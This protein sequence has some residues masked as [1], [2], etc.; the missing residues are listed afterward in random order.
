MRSV[1]F[2]IWL[3][4]ALACGFLD[5][6][7]G[8]NHGEN[9]TFNCNSLGGTC[10]C[11]M[12]AASGQCG[13]ATAHFSNAVCDGGTDDHV[14]M[15]DWLT[16][17]N[18]FYPGVSPALYVPPVCKLHLDPN[19]ASCSFQA[20]VLAGEVG[21]PNNSITWAYGATTDC[22]WI[23]GFAYPN[24]TVSGVPQQALINTVTAGSSTV[25]VNDGNIGTFSIG[26]SIAVTGLVTIDNQSGNPSHQ[27]FEYKKITNIVGNVITLDSPLA[28]SYESTWPSLGLGD[29]FH[30]ALGG[31][32]L[33][34]LLDATWDV[35]GTIYGIS[36]TYS[37]QVN[38]VGR[39]ISAIDVT[40]PTP[41]GYAPTSSKNVYISGGSTPTIEVDKNIEVFS[42]NN[43]SVASS[44][45]VQ[46]NMGTMNLSGVVGASLGGTT[47]NTTVS[48]SRF[49]AIR[50]GP[51]CCG[52]G[53]SLTFNN[54]TFTIASPNFHFGLISN[55]TFSGGNLIIAASSSAWKNADIALWIPGHKYFVGDSDGSNTCSPSNEFT[56]NDVSVNGS[57]INIAVSGLSSLSFGN[58]CSLGTRAPTTFGSFNVMTFSATNSGP[59]N[60]LSNPELI[61]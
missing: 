37:G 29:A 5:G 53:N 40:F 50:A 42:L 21:L 45:I 14:A 7:A 16:Y 19:D 28:N 57:N 1:V 24:G 18:G 25:T 23:G 6:S 34:Y 41:N 55:Y 31:P 9:T 44:I 58:T 43:T 30:P 26:R 10:A 13:S 3:L 20:D 59:G 61:P 17:A 52:A 39:N 22:L 8:I 60:M 15:K 48:N 12:S 33:I 38:V 32:A 35:A 49:N 54:V 56:V 46:S 47:T 36:T 4:G 51:T 11:F 27:R 2:F